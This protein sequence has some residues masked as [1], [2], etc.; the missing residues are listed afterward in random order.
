[1]MQQNNI[2]VRNLL[3]SNPELEELPQNA[4]PTYTRQVLARNT[5]KFLLTGESDNTQAGYQTLS[6]QL[7][8]RSLLL[9]KDSSLLY[10]LRSE[11]RK[12]LQ[13][14]FSQIKNIPGDDAFHELIQ[15]N[16]AN[17]LSYYSIFE[18]TPHD[19]CLQIPRLIDGQYRLVD[20][21]VEPIELTP[22]LGQ[23]ELLT[24]ENRVFAYG[25]TPLSHIKANRI[26]MF[27]GTTFPTG[28]GLKTQ[29]EVN[30]YP[31]SSLGEGYSWQGIE[32]WLDLDQ[33]K[34]V[35]VCGASQ[36]GGL[37]LLV[38][39]KSPEKIKRVDALNPPGMLVDYDA[40]HPTLGAWDRALRDGKAVPKV[41][42]QAQAGD[43]VSSV[44]YWKRHWDIL[45]ITPG[46][47][48][49]VPIIKYHFAHIANFVGQRDTQVRPMLGSEDN[50]FK[51]HL[52]TQLVFNYLRK[53]R[54]YTR[55]VVGVPLIW[56][57]QMKRW[58]GFGA[59]VISNSGEALIHT[60]AYFQSS[61]EPLDPQYAQDFPSR[62]ITRAYAKS[63]NIEV[64]PISHAE[65][66]EPKKRS[67][68]S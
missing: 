62:R 48:I 61:V 46:H 28:Q 8:L 40:T 67:T 55:L 53:A 44:G 41:V 52:L 37:S 4:S 42:I 7:F 30:M 9:R 14:L 29:R 57:K 11:T 15:L 64:E 51:R 34:L 22:F 38:A 31:F 45:K 1:M 36:G 2:T 26:L 16:I 60:K 25:L 58:L 21:K 17:L 33:D 47:T 6:N 49:P 65:E 39:L 56:F 20:F 27:S 50:T 23:T 68:L 32:R 18:P 12:V 63:L 13:H 66:A 10:V 54:Y 59:Q 3:F 24:D 43:P 19:G 5:L 35:E